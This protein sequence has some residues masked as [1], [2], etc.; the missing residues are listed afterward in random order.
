M[1]WVDREQREGNFLQLFGLYQLAAKCCLFHIA[2][3]KGN[4]VKVSFFNRM[5]YFSWQIGVPYQVN[6]MYNWSNIFAV[7]IGL[8]GNNMKVSFFSRLAY[9][10][11]QL[12][13]A[14]STQPDSKGTTRVC[15]D[16]D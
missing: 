15:R 5:A 3:S 2:R 8:K 9:I 11:W 7:Y 13:V 6:P 10:S 4:N 14:Y 16:I 1:R 12:S